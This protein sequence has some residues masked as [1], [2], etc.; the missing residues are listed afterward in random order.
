MNLGIVLTN[1][2]QSEEAEYCY[3]T[4]ISHRN[5]YPDCY[6][7]LGNLVCI[8]FIL[9]V[10]FF[11]L[12]LGTPLSE[13]LLR[14]TMYFLQY[15]DLKRNDDALKAWEMAVSYRP[16]HTAAWSNTLVLL[17]SMQKYNE[18]LDLGRIA[19]TNNPKSP[20]LHFSIANTL[21]KLQQFEK[22]EKHFLEA[23]NFNPYNALYYSNLGE[24]RSVFLCCFINIIV[25]LLILS[26]CFSKN[27]KII[28]D[29]ILVEMY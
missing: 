26:S 4:A 29:F 5:K 12:F 1:L 28:S 2:N 17:D 16:T 20:A 19:L 14:Y 8:L 9:N 15:L 21:G 11:I 3:L 25:I 23:L 10:F 13:C 18:A 7:N 6:Y 22:A 24:K 27:S